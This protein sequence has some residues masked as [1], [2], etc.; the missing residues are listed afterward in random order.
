MVD[1]SFVLFLVD[2]IGSNRV[3]LFGFGFGFVTLEFEV[4]GWQFGFYIECNVC[5]W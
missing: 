5:T 1:L 2:K 4:L 3:E